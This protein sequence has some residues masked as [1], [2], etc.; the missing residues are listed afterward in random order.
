MPLAVPDL[1]TLDEDVVQQALDL[2]TQRVGEY[3]PSVQRKRGVVREIVLRLHA[4]LAAS[5]AGVIDEQVDKAGS[6]LRINEDPSNADPDMV[7]RL[8]SNFRV[9]RREGSNAAGP[10]TVVVDRLSPLSVPKGT[11]FESNGLTFTTNAAYAART[12]A[13]SVVTATDRLLRPAGGT[14]YAFTVDVTA[15]APG[16]A[17]MLKRGTPL[18]PQ[19]LI[20]N[21]VRA[22]AGADFSGGVDTETNEELLSR[23]QEGL[24]D[25]SSSNRV[26]I[27]S[28]VR[29]EPDFAGV[30][31]VSSVGYGDPEQ[32]RY[33][34]IFPVAHGGRVDVYARTQALP[35][36][37][38]LTKSCSLVEKRAA[39]GVWQFSLA[40]D[41]APGFYEVRRVVVSGADETAQTGFEVLETVRGFDL[42]GDGTGF[43]PDVETADEAAFSRYQTATVRFLDTDTDVSG[44]AVGAKADYDAVVSV[45]PLVAELQSFLGGRDRRP[46]AADL[47]VKAPVPMYL[48]LNL[49]LYKRSGQE[50]PDV[51]A[52]KTALAAYVN[53]LGFAG[54]LDA[55]ALAHVV[56][57][58]VPD[59]M[60]ASAVDM[61][62]RIVKPD[63]TLKYV[64]S[65][66]TLLV[67]DLTAT[68]V[69]PRTVAIY[70]DPD[71]VS[72]GIVAV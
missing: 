71:D 36:E 6:L 48:T 4:V 30:L 7:D 18:T 34:S 55:S 51:G 9:V 27:S 20:Q 11:K 39:G 52:V 31:A 24:A 23:L 44:T 19:T 59:G 57:R 46:A 70:L 67:P 5:T 38:K 35:R 22:A 41:D 14:D 66:E 45:M 2:I 42:A 64:R 37:V 29:N 25:R 68:M 15:E 40:R 54:R 49:N 60:T 3:S 32:V 28:M 72:V 33:H 10:V 12:S 16:A 13:A 62:G 43:T 63:G 65:D 17:G 47:L 53:S 69:S 8:L 58:N 21:Y 61:F 50:D 1:T 26:T 56:L